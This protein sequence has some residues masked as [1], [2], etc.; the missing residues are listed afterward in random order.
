[1]KLTSATSALFDASASVFVF[2]GVKGEPNKVHHEKDRVRGECLPTFGLSME[3]VRGP[4][5]EPRWGLRIAHLEAEQ[6]AP[7]PAAERDTASSLNAR[8][9]RI[10]T[11]LRLHSPFPG[12]KGALAEQLGMGRTAFFDALSVLESR[13]EVVQEGSR[14]GSRFRFVASQLEVQP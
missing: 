1:M 7:K 11:Y 8:V 12:S 13:G 10:R 3:D 2:E 4:A 9:E 5:G 6:V 14:G